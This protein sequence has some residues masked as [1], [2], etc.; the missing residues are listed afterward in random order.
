MKKTIGIE[1]RTDDPEAT[2]TISSEIDWP[3]D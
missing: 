3:H 2:S 1:Y